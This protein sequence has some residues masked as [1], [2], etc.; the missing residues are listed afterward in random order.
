MQIVVETIEADSSVVSK[1]V[2]QIAGSWECWQVSE[3]Q[4]D[5]GCT[6]GGSVA[7]GL[8]KP[9]SLQLRTIIIITLFEESTA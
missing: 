9:V 6:V 2:E 3:Q 1:V 5:E 8:E 4:A 7:I